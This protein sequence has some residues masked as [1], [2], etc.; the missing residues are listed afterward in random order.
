[1][2]GKKSDASEF[3]YKNEKGKIIPLDE[4]NIEIMKR[5]L[6]DATV[7]DSALSTKLNLS[8]ANIQ[9]RRKML[10]SLDE[11]DRQSKDQNRCAYHGSPEA[12]FIPLSRLG[13]ILRLVDLA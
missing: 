5:M 13:E 9:R 3:L 10:V 12:V 6:N 7:S 8:D 11:S 1:M 4:V 2:K